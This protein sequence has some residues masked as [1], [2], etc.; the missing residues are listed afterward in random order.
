QECASSIQGR[1]ETWINNEIIRAFCELHALGFAHSVECWRN[2]ALVG[3]LYGVGLAGAFCG[4]SMFSRERDAS[5]VALVHLVARLRLGG[6]RLLDAQFMTEHL[7][8]FGAIE[9]PARDY[10]EMLNNAL[11]IHATFVPNPDAV[12]LDAELN[13]LFCRTSADGTHD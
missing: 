4:E 8:Q 11:E 1:G 3:G 5:K 13:A 10:L 12:R 7:R 9:I 6:I 2:G